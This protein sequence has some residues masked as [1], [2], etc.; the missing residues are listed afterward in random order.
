MG[1]VGGHVIGWWAR[2]GTEQEQGKAGQ[3]AGQEGATG[4]EQASRQARAM[5]LAGTVQ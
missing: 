1:G 4:Q 5:W 3:A 2:R